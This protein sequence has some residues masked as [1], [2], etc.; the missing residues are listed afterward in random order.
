M[1]KIKD[2]SGKISATEKN[3]AIKSLSDE[4]GNRANPYFSSF[5][6]IITEVANATA[7]W[8]KGT[9]LEKVTQQVEEQETAFYGLSYAYLDLKSKAKLTADETKRYNDIIL[10]LQKKYGEYLKNVDLE[11]DGYN[12]VK[13]AIDGATIAL[14]KN[15]AVKLA[16]AELEDLTEK[17][18]KDQLS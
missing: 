7:E 9:N 8:V 2:T 1:D 10:E 3:E 17:Q 15:I 18:V 4:I 5:L 14:Q 13:D 12:K 6:G 11:K 16:R